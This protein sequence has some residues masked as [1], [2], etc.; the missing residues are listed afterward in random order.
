MLGFNS[1]NSLIALLAIGTLLV[2]AYVILNNQQNNFASTDNPDVIS[3]PSPI[4][5]TEISS[6]EDCITAGNP[7]MESYPRQCRSNG[8]GFVEDIGNELEKSD[9]IRLEN[10]R[11]NQEIASPL[12]ISGEARGTWYFEATFPIRLIDSDGNDLY[13]GFATARGEWMTE[14]FV[15]FEVDI[16]FDTPEVGFGTLILEKANP[17][18]LSENTDELRVPVQF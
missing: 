12:T 2:G 13:T 7:V 3:T 14:E 18:G 15:P 8:Q 16:T 4:Q 10:P 9:L 6:F 5:T 11:A 17:S 1:N